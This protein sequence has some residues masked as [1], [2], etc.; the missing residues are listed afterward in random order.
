MRK[1]AAPPAAYAA[2][3]PR[4][5]RRPGGRRCRAVPVIAAISRVDVSAAPGRSA[6]TAP[7]R[8][9]WIR[10][11]MSS[12]S[13]SRWLT[14]TTVWP[15]SRQRR[16]AS[17]RTLGLG[18]RQARGGFVED[19]RESA[20][21]VDIAQC[22]GDGGRV[23]SLGRSSRTSRRGSR[24][25]SARSSAS[26][27]VRCSTRHAIR[28]GPRSGKPPSRPKFSLM[29][30]SGTSRGPGRRTATRQPLRS[31][32]STTTSGVRPRGPRSCR[33]RLGAHRRGSSTSSTCRIRCR[34]AGRAPC[35]ARR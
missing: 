10:S 8:R 22:A 23:R 31:L 18:S 24:S 35:R 11:A 7:S 30:R 17:S 1:R 34:R 5:P 33:R 19:D 15:R 29:D 9:T 13:V 14:Y 27:V 20:T 32:R 4:G 26:W 28:P 6:A 21:R 3:R 25:T 16:T 12:T 2:R